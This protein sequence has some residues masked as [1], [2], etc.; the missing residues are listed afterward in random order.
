M[1]DK[2]AGRAWFYSQ[3]SLEVPDAKKCSDVKIYKLC[4]TGQ[5]ICEIFIDSGVGGDA[6]EID[7]ITDIHF[8]YASEEDE[9]DE[10][11]AHTK[12]C[13]KWNHDAASVRSAVKAMDVASFADQTVITGDTL[14]YLSRGAMELTKKLIIDRDPDIMMALGAHDYTKQMQTGLPNRLSAEERLAILE[15][16]WPHCMFYHSKAI[17]KVIAVCMDNSH[18]FH[19]S[20]F[21]KLEAEIK[22]ARAEKKIILAFFHEPIRTNVPGCETRAVLAAEGA[23]DKHDFDKAPTLGCDG[24]D[25]HTLAVCSLISENA[26]VIRGVFCGHMH[27]AFYTEIKASYKDESGR[28]DALIP[29][30]CAPGNPYRDHAGTV[31]RII[32]N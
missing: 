15:S 21:E 26:D 2:E 8:N 18:G 23:P 30:F 32:I 1:T 7:Q 17:G 24:S 10:E 9:C 3:G 19:P 28:H 20:V 31:T 14:D 13:R 25:V 29:Q 16:I 6:V 11:I 4:R 12:E 5:Y 27:C 22:R